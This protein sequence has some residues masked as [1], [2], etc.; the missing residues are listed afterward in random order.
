MI[1]DYNRLAGIDKIAIL[2]TVVGEGLAVKLVRGL[3]EADV[4]RIRA[5]VREMETISTAVKKQ[6][7]DEFYLALISKKLQADGDGSD[8]KKPFAFIDALADEQLAALLEV[9]EPRIIAMALAQ[10]SSDRQMY[11][12]NKL[13]PESRSRVLMEMGNLQDVPLEAVVNIATELEH[14]S[15]FLPRAVEF[16]RG[17]GQGIADILGQMNPEEES[18]F[19]DAVDRESPDLAK[20]IKK[21]HLTFDNILVFPDGLLRDIMNSVELDAIALAMKGQE[22]AVIDK[23][24]ENLPQKKQ[25]MFEPV[26]GPVPKRDVDS[27]RKSIVDA[28]RQMEKD[29]RFN[30]EDILGGSEMIE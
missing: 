20:E 27:A 24:I 29:G 23:V 13:S 1:T 26:E 14:K 8:A 19:L 21:Y 25:A 9:E 11:V 2:F 16:S 15:H 18:R 7:M 28:A 17:G 5:R 3:G 10:V 6:V 4:R 12:M 22:Q 30:L